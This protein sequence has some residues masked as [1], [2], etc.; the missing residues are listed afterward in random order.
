MKWVAT[1]LALLLNLLNASALE[2]TET[3]SG[4]VISETK[5]VLP[6]A[7]VSTT[8]GKFALTD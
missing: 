1:T 4:V 2:H 5:E 6:F 8:N 7:H 3:K